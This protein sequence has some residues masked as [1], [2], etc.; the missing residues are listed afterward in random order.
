MPTFTIH[1]LGID[2]QVHLV[3]LQ[4]DNFRLY[5]ELT[6]NVLRKIDLSS[7]FRLMSPCLHACLHVSML[8]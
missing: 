8:V 3:R 4:T 6:V 1:N 2:G 5:D 7:V